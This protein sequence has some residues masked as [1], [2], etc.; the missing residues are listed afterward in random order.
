MNPQEASTWNC[1][2]QK[3]GA[4]F[5]QYYKENYKT[6]FLMASKYLKDPLQAQ[7]IVNDIFIKLWQDGERIQIE[8]SLKSYIYRS[9]IN[10]SINAN[11]KLQKDLQNQKEHSYQFEEA[12]VLR[13][14]E[15]NELRVR[16][17]KAIDQLPTQCQTVF[18]MSRFEGLKQ[19]EIAD[20][21]G[22]SLKTVKNHITYALKQLNK[23]LGDYLFLLAILIKKIF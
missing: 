6:F 13:H 2:Q 12:V 16:L 4:V 20:K 18:S 11:N 14:I 15:D 17:F 10:R 22:I 19:Q 21:L 8:S 7:E 5:E 23:A 9:V 3:N 1:I